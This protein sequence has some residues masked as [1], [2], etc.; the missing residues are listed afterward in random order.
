MTSSDRQTVRARILASFGARGATVDELLAFNEPIPPD[1]VLPLCFPLPAE[2]HGVAWEAWCAAAG[3]QGAWEV[4]RLRLPQFLF[5]IREGISRTDAY[6]AATRQVAAQPPPGEAPG[7]VLNAPDQFRLWLHPSAA[8]PIPVLCTADRGDF[9]LLVQALSCRNE[10]EP[11]PASM[12][13]CLVSGFNN[14]DRLRRY[15][16]HSGDAFRRILPARELYQDRF[17]IL[18]EGPYSDVPAEAMNLAPEAWRR[19]S[20]TIRLEHECA[21]YLTLRLFSAMRNHPLDELLADHAGITAAL[22]CYRADWFLRFVGLEEFPH[23]RQGGRLEN[24][25]G[26]P[27]ISD[28]AF[29]VLQALVVAAARNLERCEAGWLSRWAGPWARAALLAALFTRTLEELAGL[30]P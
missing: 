12:G 22:G 7:L 14:L 5:P 18:S 17:L 21:H 4:L 26:Q 28:S 10:P 30:D 20:L 9:V 29:E 2:S 8:G 11:V 23:Y 3:H 27:P 13:A 1:P 6:R 25:R 19:L 15:R 24:Y 16:E